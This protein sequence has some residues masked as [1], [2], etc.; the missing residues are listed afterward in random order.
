MRRAIKKLQR[1]RSIFDKVREPC[2]PEYAHLRILS[3]FS[4]L[5]EKSF[6]LSVT[7]MP[8]P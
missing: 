5:R 8:M 1:N 6:D 2:I 4:G 7:I 3:F